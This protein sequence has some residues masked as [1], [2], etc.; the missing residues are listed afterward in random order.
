MH[1]F[2]VR[3]DL[4]RG[5]CS[6]GFTLSESW[7]LSCVPPTIQQCCRINIHSAPC[8]TL[9]DSY[10][11]RPDHQ[12]HWQFIG[13]PRRYQNSCGN[14][15]KSKLSFMMNCWQFLPSTPKLSLLLWFKSYFNTCADKTVFHQRKYISVLL[16]KNHVMLFGAV[17]G[18]HQ[19]RMVIFLQTLSQPI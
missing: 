6:Y 9:A 11:V 10:P 2:R 19:V 18:R 7:P 15:S 12:W 13:S 4:S 17:D 16:W 5:V 8:H 14:S 3:I 1:H